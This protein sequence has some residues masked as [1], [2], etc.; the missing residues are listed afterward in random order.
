MLNGE[1]EEMESRNPN[2]HTTH[3]K[4]AKENRT[5]ERI[6]RLGRVLVHVDATHALDAHQLE[7]LARVIGAQRVALAKQ[8]DALLEV[9]A[10]KW[11]M[12]SKRRAKRGRAGGRCAHA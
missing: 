11:C 9:G 3:C 12:E 8:V 7:Q 6:E 10:I 2:T 4:Q 5:V 1:V